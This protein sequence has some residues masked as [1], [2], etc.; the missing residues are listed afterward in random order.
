MNSLAHDSS[1][2]AWFSFVF[3][4]NRLFASSFLAFSRTLVTST[5]IQK[6]TCISIN[7]WISWS[8]VEYV[9]EFRVVCRFRQAD[10]FSPSTGFSSSISPHGF[11]A[12]VGILAT[13]RACRNCFL[14]NWGKAF[15][16]KIETVTATQTSHWQ[17]KSNS[18]KGFLRSKPDH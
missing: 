17:F 11:G 16:P 2:L 3:C 1:D 5:I 9:E 12:L 8:N 18:R 6:L 15:E 7:R 4:N 10:F 14:C 13:H